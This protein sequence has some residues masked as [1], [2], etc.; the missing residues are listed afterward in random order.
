MPITLIP[1]LIQAVALLK[2]RVRNM[3]REF[4]SPASMKKIV[5]MIQAVPLK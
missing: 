3:S 4:I 2:K 1:I 5:C